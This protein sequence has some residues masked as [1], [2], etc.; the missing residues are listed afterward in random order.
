MMKRL[1]MLAALGLLGGNAWA[2]QIETLPVED[3][4][5]CDRTERL[6]CPI[7]L[8]RCYCGDTTPV[9]PAETGY[10]KGEGGNPF[11]IPGEPEPQ[12]EPK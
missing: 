6:I 2:Q 12:P 10:S 11:R 9:A 3:V 7:F 8:D 4:P 1:A 5:R